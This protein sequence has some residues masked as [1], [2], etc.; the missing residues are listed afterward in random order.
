MVR[1]SGARGPG[2]GQEEPAV[3]GQNCMRKC[4]VQDELCTEP[5]PS[6]ATRVLGNEEGDLGTLEAPQGTMDALRFK[7]ERALLCFPSGVEDRCACGVTQNQW[8]VQYWL[9][10]ERE[11]GSRPVRGHRLTGPAQ[12]MRPEL[13]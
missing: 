12:A 9:E 5:R 11:E 1:T 3:Q 10:E 7:Q 8:C 13:S 6:T 2:A 4:G